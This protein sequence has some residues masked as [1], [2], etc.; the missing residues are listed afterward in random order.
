MTLKSKIYLSI[1][2]LTILFNFI[3]WNE[4]MGLNITVFV[5]L[6][7]LITYIINKD[8]A[9]S[10]N[11]VYSLIAVI[12]SGVM[13]IINNSGFSKFSLILSCIVTVGFIH[14]SQLRSVI[15]STLT[16]LASY[17]MFPV[18]A[19]DAVNSAIDEHKNVAKLFKALRLTIIPLAVFLIFYG[20]YAF[21]NPTFNSYS[22]SF[23]DY[24]GIYLN[25]IFINYP[26]KRIAFI[27]FGL[28][29]VSGI[30]YKRN[31][32]VFVKI[33][34][35]YLNNLIRDKYRKLVTHAD[36]KNEMGKK[37]KG[38]FPYKMTSLLTEYRIGLILIVMV[39][40]LLLILNIIDISFVWFGF[41]SSQ[42]GNLAY[43]VH[44]G[45]YYLIFSIVLSMTILLYFFRGNINFYSKNKVLKYGAYLWIFQNA[46]M[47]VSVALRNYYYIEYYYA[48]SPK[49]VGVMIF[50]TLTF[51]GLISMF[52]KIYKK[53]T[54]FYLIKVN[55]LA[56]FLVMILMGS[57]NWD[58]NIA[59]FNLQNPDKSQIDLLYL[60][61]LSDAAL[62]V[63]Y[64][65]KELF[66]KEVKM[67][68]GWRID[69]VNGL[70]ELEERKQN[71]IDEHELYTWLSWNYSDE[72]VNNYFKNNT[73]ERVQK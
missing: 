30:I 69:Y 20:I 44:N 65:N 48:L 15:S 7:C 31:I 27:F 33:D 61:E 49:R 4:K 25:D 29:L 63:L 64:E 35:S 60:L 19:L 14:Q 1:A 70:K 2:A 41:D 66:D 45:T 55:S 39:N 9:I 68:S 32:K 56:V 28:F 53:K 52:I 10:R 12:Y 72:K 73:F 34:L 58:E 36:E 18:N 6:L 43:Y 17:T 26:F 54:L 57:V 71:F 22:N 62:P 40:L 42:V 11:V 24:V 59:K 21:S 50:L 51:I 37:F 38:F 3:F 8:S 13:V 67:K 16:S 47:A 23:W 5:I 46:V